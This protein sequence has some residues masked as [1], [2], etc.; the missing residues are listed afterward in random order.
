[1]TSAREGS[2]YVRVLP[3]LVK[4][5]ESSFPVQLYEPCSGDAVTGLVTPAT[6]IVALLLTFVTSKDPD[7]AAV[8]DGN[9]RSSVIVPLNLAEPSLPASGVP[10][11][12]LPRAFPL[13][14]MY[15]VVFTP[16]V[17]VSPVVLSVRRVTFQRPSRQGRLPAWFDLLLRCFL[18][19]FMTNSMW[20]A[21]GPVPTREEREPEAGRERSGQ[22]HGNAESHHF[23]CDLEDA[24]RWGLHLF[25]FRLTTA[26]EV[27]TPRHLGL[28]GRRHPE[29]DRQKELEPCG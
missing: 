27:S 19:C 16:P 9:P 22:G 1:M 11:V 24:K 20:P 21:S 8:L 29:I 5:S 18:L 23:G 7:W 6:V 13:D 26:S 17:N 15:T 4:T 25:R 2:W 3:P 14:M 28:R 12:K 10:G